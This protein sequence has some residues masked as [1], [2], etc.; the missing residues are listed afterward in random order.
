MYR[1]SKGK[2]ATTTTTT[3]TNITNSS[4]IQQQ[5][6]AVPN[7]AYGVINVPT[8]MENVAYSALTT[9]IYD[10]ADALANKQ[11]ETVHDYI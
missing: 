1:R 9:P 6:T 11:Y 4:V 5:F 3:V 7:A 2:K 10:T 8:M